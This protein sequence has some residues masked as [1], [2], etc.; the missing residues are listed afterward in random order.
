M[1]IK[2]GDYVVRKS[3]DRDIIFK[4]KQIFQDENGGLSAVLKGVAIRLL[5]D[6]PLMDLEQLNAEENSTTHGRRRR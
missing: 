3:Y 4:V 1:K 6:A 2:S 5:A